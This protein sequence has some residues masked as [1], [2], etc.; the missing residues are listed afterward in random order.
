MDKL[1]IDQLSEEMESKI[2]LLATEKEIVF[3]KAGKQQG[4][5]IWRIEKAEVKQWPIDLFGK[6]FQ[7]DSYIVLN[8]ISF[9]EINAHLW[10]GKDSTS[11]EIGTASFKIL[12]LDEILNHKC[13]IF[14]EVQGKESVLFLSYFPIFTI[15]QGGMDPDYIS[16]TSHKFRPR[17]FQIKGVGKNIHSKE[18]PLRRN[19]LNS[20]DVF[21]FDVGLKLFNWRGI[22][23]SSFEKY[24]GTYLCELIKKKRHYKIEII[25]IDE[26]DTTSSGLQTQKLFDELFEKGEIDYKELIDY[27]NKEKENI[28]NVNIS[29]NQPKVMMKLSNTNGKF[30]FTNVNY[31]KSTLDS[32]DVFLIDRL[33]AIIIWIGKNANKTEKRFA[34][35]YGKRYLANNKNNENLPII[36][37]HE[38]RL[39][40]ELDKCFIDLI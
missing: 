29:N 32:N 4:I 8:I 6:F 21:L 22:S 19:N 18:V 34:F 26:G 20:E 27:Q 37:I 40:D 33:D 24:H 30:L 38:G 15:L 35:A 10:I 7:G 31:G 36:T 5:Q 39:N 23:S 9:E 2:N 12:Q 11:D 17:L 14:Y 13:S 16:E 3:Q 28:S 25:S 1:F